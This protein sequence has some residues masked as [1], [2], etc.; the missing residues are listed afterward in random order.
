MFCAIP[1]P[2]H[3]WDE[4]CV[5]YALP[6]FPLVGGIIGLLWWGFARLLV[7]GGV[8]IVLA[9]ALLGLF[10]FL[11]TGFLHLDGYMDTNDAILSRRPAEDRL[12]I[13][14][15]PHMGAFAVIMLAVLLLFQV[16]AAYALI[17]K[18]TDFYM[19]VVISVVSR[20]CSSVSLLCLNIMPQSGYAKMFRQKAGLRHMLFIA[21]TAAVFAAFSVIIKGPGSL[22]AAAPVVL[23]YAASTAYAYKYFKGVSGDLAGYALTISELAGLVVLAIL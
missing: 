4:D 11:A 6:C 16:A 7:F 10:P 19:L 15:D 8:H 18:G 20:S 14:K 3:I 22:A 23:A 5:Q 13:L 9:S 2:K 21:V 1:L 12:R 17:E